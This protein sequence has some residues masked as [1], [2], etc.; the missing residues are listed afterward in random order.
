M[1]KCQELGILYLTNTDRTGSIDQKGDAK[2]MVIN[3]A[4]VQQLGVSYY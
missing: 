3:V 1:I 4:E 2:Y